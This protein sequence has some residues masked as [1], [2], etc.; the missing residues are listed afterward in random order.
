MSKDLALTEGSV[1]SR[2][3]V[4][5]LVKRVAKA[6]DELKEPTNEDIIALCTENA[7]RNCAFLF[8]ITFC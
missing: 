3:R 6:I 4:L 8:Y 2:Q 7:S 1:K 5:R